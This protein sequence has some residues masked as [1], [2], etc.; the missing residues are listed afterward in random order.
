MKKH[1][2][3]FEPLPGYSERFVIRYLDRSGELPKQK[4]VVVYGKRKDQLAIAAE[5]VARTFKIANG[6]IIS[7]NYQ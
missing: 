1:A 7:A 2:V 6:D 3:A 4:A 5:T